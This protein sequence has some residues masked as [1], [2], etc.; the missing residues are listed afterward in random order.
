MVFLKTKL[1]IIVSEFFLLLNLGQAYASELTCENFGL[2]IKGTKE[3]ATVPNL[4][5]R[6]EVFLT[7]SGLPVNADSVEIDS[8]NYLSYAEN[9]IP[10]TIE[11]LMVKGSAINHLSVRIGDQ[12]FRRKTNSQVAESNH[13]NF[14]SKNLRWNSVEGVVL[15]ITSEEFLLLL[16]FYKKIET[17]GY[18]EF[19]FFKDNCTTIICHLLQTVNIDTPGMLGR[20]IPSLTFQ[21]YLNSDR[22]VLHTVYLG[23]PGPR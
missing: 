2:I 15:R 4:I 5:N 10:G 14:L 1:V 23:V 6:L 7:E 21:H 18:S 8:V 22:M 3:L 9:I 16:D 12:V 19:N 11:I 17:E 13:L 20:R